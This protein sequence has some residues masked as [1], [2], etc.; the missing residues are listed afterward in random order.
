[1]GIPSICWEVFLRNFHVF[2]GL[3]VGDVKIG[4]LDDDELIGVEMDGI[5][6]VCCIRL[7]GDVARLLIKGDLSSSSVG[8][9]T[10]R[11]KLC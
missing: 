8:P 2:V 3:V 11:T 7:R 10:L 5:A 4:E 1:V 9:R 6:K